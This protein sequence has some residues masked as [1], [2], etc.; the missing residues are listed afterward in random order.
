MIFKA[1]NGHPRALKLRERPILRERL[2]LAI[3]LTAS[4]LSAS[5]GNFD[6]ARQRIASGGGTASNAEFTV[7]ATIGQAE[8]GAIARGGRFELS[9]GFLKRAALAEGDLLFRDDFENTQN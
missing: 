7:V 5:A 9:G 2:A 1:I 3:L 6:L 8:A 4:S